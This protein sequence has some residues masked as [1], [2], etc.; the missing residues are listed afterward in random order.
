M[1]TALPIGEEYTGGV[2]GHGPAYWGGVHGRSTW[3]RLCLLGRCTREEYMV[4]AQPTSGYTLVSTPSGLCESCHAII[5]HRTLTPTRA[6]FNNTHHVCQHAPCLPT[7][8]ML[9]GCGC[10]QGYFFHHHVALLLP[11]SR[12]SPSSTIT[13]LSFALQ[14]HF[15]S[16]L[17]IYI[18]VLWSVALPS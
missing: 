4:T 8:A 17:P 11:P 6:M 5:R 2:H 18:P 16:L 10:L 12:G 14:T 1:V 15:S 9:A 3:P 13:W 7:C